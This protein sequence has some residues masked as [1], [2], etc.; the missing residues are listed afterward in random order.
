[1]LVELFFE[2]VENFF[3]MFVDCIPKGLTLVERNCLDFFAG[4]VNGLLVGT[5]GL[6]DFCTHFVNLGAELIV[7]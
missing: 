6:I 2:Y 5:H 1:M 7:R 4:L 3:L